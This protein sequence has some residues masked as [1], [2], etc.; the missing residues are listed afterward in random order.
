MKSTTR[1]HGFNG[2][3]QVTCLHV[4][5]TR[6]HASY[7]YACRGW[8]LGFLGRM[9]AIGELTLTSRHEF[10]PNG[11]LTHWLASKIWLLRSAEEISW[12]HGGTEHNTSGFLKTGRSCS[13]ESARGSCASF[14]CCQESTVVWHLSARCSAA[15]VAQFFFYLFP[16]TINLPTSSS[17]LIFSQSICRL[18]PDKSSR[19]NQWNLLHRLFV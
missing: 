8:G 6:L 11:S 1:C 9:A 5:R 7:R 10:A 19:R 14:L 16:F 18:K 12:E 2:T 4:E 15:L 3:I 13:H 17:Y